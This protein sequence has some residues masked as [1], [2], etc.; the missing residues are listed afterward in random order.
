MTNVQTTELAA[1]ASGDLPKRG[2]RYSLDQILAEIK[3][4]DEDRETAQD[5]IRKAQNDLE[6]AERR[7]ESSSQA[8]KEHGERRRAWAMELQYHLGQATRPVEYEDDDK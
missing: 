4:A 5:E 3:D 8:E 2:V 7:L 6:R 1:S